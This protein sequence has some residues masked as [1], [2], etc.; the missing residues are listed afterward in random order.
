MKKNANGKGKTMKKKIK[1]Y[2]SKCCKAVVV[3]T[4]SQDFIGDVSDQMHVGTCYYE[5]SECGKPCDIYT[6]KKKTEKTCKL[7]D[8]YK[9]LK[10]RP[11]CN[12]CIYESDLYDAYCLRIIETLEG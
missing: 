1:E 6:G 11:F 10:A 9:L 12:E 3:G 7:S 5:C 4:M 8:V 2:L